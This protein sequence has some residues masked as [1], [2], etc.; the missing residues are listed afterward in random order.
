MALAGA[1]ILNA[2]R[3]DWD[4]PLAQ[5]PSLSLAAGL[6]T[7]GL[8]VLVMKPL[9]ERTLRADA[10]TQQVCLWLV[11]CLGLVLRVMM[12]ATQPALEDDQQRY[13]FEGAM[14]ANG[15]S[16]YRM[17]PADAAHAAPGTIA[18]QL[19][20]RSW[21]VIERVN[22]AMLKTIYPPLAQGAFALAYAIKPFSVQAWRAV[23]L[24][25]DAGILVLLCRLLAMTGRPL[26]WVALYWWH[27]IAVKEL[28]NSGHMEGVLML[29]VVL[30]VYLAAR[31]RFLWATMALGFAVGVKIWP[32]LLAP[33]LLRP[34]LSRPWLGAAAIGLLMA[35]CVAWAVPIVLGGLDERSGFLAYAERWQ[36]NSALLPGLRDVIQ[37]GLD[38]LGLGPWPAG[39]IA[40]GL[41]AVTAA[42]I[43]LAASI[44]VIVD[45][46]DLLR[47][48][49]VV[50]LALALLSPAQ[51][52]WYML[53]TL[54]FLPFAP[55]WS[56]IA[57]AVTV[58]LYYVSFHYTAIGSPHVFRERIV[59][60]IWLPIWTL[61]GIELLNTWRT[62][63]AHQA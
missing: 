62:R 18:S 14:V 30:A 3:F 41:L 27:P 22:H 55:R 61:L 43:A 53:W 35:L 49:A 59:W 7:A 23:L 37:Y 57:M 4:L 52:P 26:L 50:T 24:A 25:A 44:R 48:V 56:V 28:F 39:R 46:S 60:A 19:A 58:P 63:A 11:I 15:I 5:T 38:G 40:R 20:V 2:H 6:V 13:L 36:A 12:F 17:A 54:P 10:R 29:F 42:G 9:I 16:P 32:V 34:I 33:L 21:P 1:L 45:A 47:R 51:F 31:A 8:A